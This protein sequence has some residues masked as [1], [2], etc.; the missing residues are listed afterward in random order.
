MKRLLAVFP[1]ACLVTLVP[2]F[3]GSTPPGSND[4]VEIPAGTKSPFEPTKPSIRE[5]H[6][7]D[8][9]SRLLSIGT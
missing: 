4:A 8:K 5:L 2:C 9:L 3:A 1:G 6:A 7:K